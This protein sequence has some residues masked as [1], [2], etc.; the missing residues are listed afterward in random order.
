MKTLRYT[1]LGSGSEG[2]ALLIEAAGDDE[3][4]SRLLLDCGF[5]LRDVTRRLAER[6]VAP[7]SLDAILVTH[8]HNDHVGGALRL[9][10]RHGIALYCSHGTWVSVAQSQAA[11]VAAELNPCFVCSHTAFSVGGLDIQPFPVPHDAREPTQFVFNDGQHRLGVLTDT[12]CATACIIEQLARC[13]ALVLE[14]NH[15]PQLL[16]RSDYPER[17]KQRI[18]GDYGHLSNAAAAALLD[19]LDRSRLQ[20]LHA[21]HLSRQN[22]RPELAAAALAEVLRVSAADIGIATQ[23]EGFDWVTLA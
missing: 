13:D 1:S 7:E 9:A 12:G 15:D 19:R 10:R 3:S 11:A 21:A 18:A 23:D 5:G 6:G 20:R 17:L 4:R 22:N 8:E 16:A 2:N 14:C